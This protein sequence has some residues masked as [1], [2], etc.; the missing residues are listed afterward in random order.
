MKAFKDLTEYISKVTAYLW[1]G[2]AIVFAGVIAFVHEQPWQGDRQRA[3]TSD[4]KRRQDTGE[5]K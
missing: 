3:V 1:L 2:S 4:T 5:P